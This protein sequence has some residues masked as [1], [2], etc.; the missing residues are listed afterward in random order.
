[1]KTLIFQD[2]EFNPENELDHHRDRLERVEELIVIF[3]QLTE[4]QGVFASSLINQFLKNHTLSALQ[5]AHVENLVTDVKGV[6]PLYGDFR[7]IRVAF[8]LAG[9]HLKKPKIRLITDDDIYVQLTFDVD[10]SLIFMHRDG[11]QGNGRRKFLGYIYE[12]MIR[13]RGG[14]LFT[15]SIYKLIEELAHDPQGVAKAM[16]NKLGVCT[17][18][19]QRLSD[20]I[21]KEAGYGPV[22]AEHWHLPWGDQENKPIDIG[23]SENALANF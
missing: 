21:S 14:K 17:F 6:K 18:C 5:W 16:A 19:A 2:Q 8:K 22:C 15:D 11:W 10:S 9:E 13:P 3:P 23:A 7:P 20:P 4:K 12:D 1:M